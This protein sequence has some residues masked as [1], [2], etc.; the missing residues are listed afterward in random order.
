MADQSKVAEALKKIKTKKRVEEPISE[1][2][3]IPQAE[4]NEEETKE[5]NA[6]IIAGLQNSGI[7]RKI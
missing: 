4:G 2:P 3:H 5:S 6:E 7:Y 1:D